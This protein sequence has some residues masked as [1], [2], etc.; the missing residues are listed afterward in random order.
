ML[1]KK[2]HFLL[3]E[4]EEFLSLRFIFSLTSGSIMDMIRIDRAV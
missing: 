1:V 4:A 3:S 2:E